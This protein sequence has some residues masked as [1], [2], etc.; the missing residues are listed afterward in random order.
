MGCGA[1]TSPTVATVPKE[2][3]LPPSEMGDRLKIYYRALEPMVNLDEGGAL[4][5]EPGSLKLWVGEKYR[6]WYS[7]ASLGCG[8]VT[9]DHDE[10]RR[11]MDR[12]PRSKLERWVRD[13]RKNYHNRHSLNDLNATR[14]TN[15]GS[16]CYSDEEAPEIFLTEKILRHHNNFLLKQRG[17]ASPTTSCS[18]SSV[19][20]DFLQLR[21]T[22]SSSS[23]GS[24]LTAVKT[25]KASSTRH[26]TPTTS[27]STA[28]VHSSRSLK[29]A[30]S[31]SFKL[32]AHHRRRANSKID[33]YRTHGGDTLNTPHEEGDSSLSLPT[34]VP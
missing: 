29:S 24:G 1:S 17:D 18:E 2:E 14:S 20:L 27:S 22:L 34:M 31:M 8:C 28:S 30:P 33:I 5:T 23:A 15:Y 32:Q 7:K 21:K 3:E 10:E 4:T 25:V 12:G 13:T 6:H 19:P 26:T 11:P 9:F 16:V